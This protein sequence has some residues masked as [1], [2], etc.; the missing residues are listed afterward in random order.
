M[1][2]PKDTT[3]EC[4]MKN[5]LI[6]INLRYASGVNIECVKVII[7]KLIL[8]QKSVITQALS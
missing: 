6:Y 4:D 1:N 5:K 2:E 7:K 8:L 3:T